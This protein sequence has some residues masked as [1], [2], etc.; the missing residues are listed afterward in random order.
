MTRSLIVKITLMLTAIWMC[1]VSTSGHTA[2]TSASNPGIFARPA[3]IASALNL[4]QLQARWMD[5]WG[6]D[7]DKDDHGSFDR[8]RRHDG[9]GDKDKD[10]DGDKDHDHHPGDHDH[11]G[12]EPTPEPS[13]ILSF[14][15]ALLIGGGVMYSRRLRRK[16]N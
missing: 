8:D 11:D 4:S 3:L 13:T 12:H 5:R 10:G 7:G 6:N 16:R 14:G 2:A 9:D 1:S 15:A